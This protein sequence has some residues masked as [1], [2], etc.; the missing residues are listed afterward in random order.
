MKQK[1]CD[2]KNDTSFKTR[3]ENGIKFFRI[4]NGSTYLCECSFLKLK[5]I[6]SDKRSCLNDASLSSSN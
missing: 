5:Y 4:L 2:L 3:P 1:L 6:K